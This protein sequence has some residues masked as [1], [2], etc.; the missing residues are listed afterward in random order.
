MVVLQEDIG[1][2]FQISEVSF[3]IHHADSDSYVKDFTLSMAHVESDQLTETFTAN[4]QPGSLVEVYHTDSLDLSGENGE[5]I[6]L[7]LDTPFQYNGQD[8]LLIDINYPEGYCW[9]A[10]YIWEAGPARCLSDMFLPGGSAGST[11]DLFGWVTYIVFEG[12]VSLDQCTFGAV[13]IEFGGMG[14]EQ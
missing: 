14:I 7:D 13:K 10:V 1:N 11:G 2:A 9:T 8:N 6:F 5:E 12:T 4:Y 3:V